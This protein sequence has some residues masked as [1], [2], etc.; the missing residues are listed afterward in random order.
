[1]ARL[2]VAKPTQAAPIVAAASQV[3][4]VV[5]PARRFQLDSVSVETSI[6][7]GYAGVVIGRVTVSGD[8]DDGGLFLPVPDPLP[9]GTRLNLKINGRAAEA[10]VISV[11]ESADP[12][13]AGMKVRI[14]AATAN[15]LAPSAPSAPSAA[16]AADNPGPS[17]EAVPE[18][19]DAQAD[20]GGDGV[21]S[22]DE[23]GGNSGA[24]SGGGG[25]RRRRRR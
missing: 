2:S 23:T 7:L 19:A 3:P 11:L 25:R 5:F 1:M 9:V 20:G 21:P 13:K 18:A 16:A 4:V 10:R 14:G 24:V 15:S 17:A 6:E 12:G 8:I 22:A